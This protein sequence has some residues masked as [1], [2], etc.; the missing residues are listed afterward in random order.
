MQARRQAWLGTI[1]LAQ[2]LPL[3]VGALFAGL[4]AAAVL[5]FLLLGDYTR[6][7][8]VGGQLVPDLGVSTVVAPVTGVVARLTVEEGADVAGGQALVRIELPRVAATGADAHTVIGRGLDDR[9]LSSTQLAQAQITQLSIQEHGQRRQLATLRLELGQV[10]V[11]IA[12]RGEQV[13][14]GRETAE[15]YRA[16]AESGYVSLVQVRQ[17]EQSVLEM[18]NARQALERQ[19]T[20]LVR[21]I[22]RLEQS[23]AE[24]PAQ[25]QAIDATARREH[26]LLAQERS[27]QDAEAG[28]LVK[29][30]LGGVVA[31]RFVEPG[32]VVQV[33]Q[34]LLSVLPRG[35][36]LQAQLQVPSRAIGFIRPGDRV[37]LRYQAYPFQKFGHQG[38][39]VL[40]VSRNA[41]AGAAATGSTE[42]YYRVLVQLDRQDLLAYGHAEPLRPGMLLEADILGERRRLYE[43]L[44]EPLYALRGLQASAG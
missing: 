22:A 37:Q 34:P 26:A 2:P 36:R 35:A 19:A 29:A 17:Q 9:D 20:V 43:W 33:G 28:L 38:G 3:W 42:P 24:L 5:S 25:R 21:E 4:A 41:I 23:L 8:R 1:S 30:P 12:T 31:N 13:E 32:Q 39:R 10:R 18:L 6:R 16:V 40:R 11:S 14:L 15:R 44:L 27:R 7:S